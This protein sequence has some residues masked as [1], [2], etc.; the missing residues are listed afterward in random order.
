[1][2]WNCN[3]NPRAGSNDHQKPTGN[4]LI[5]LFFKDLRKKLES[6]WLAFN[7]CVVMTQNLINKVNFWMLKARIWGLI[8][9]NS[10]SALEPVVKRTCVLP[11]R[12]HITYRLN[13]NRIYKVSF[14]IN[15]FVSGT[16]QTQTNTNKHKVENQKQTKLIII[17]I[18]IFHYL[19]LCVFFGKQ[20][21]EI[22]NLWIPDTRKQFCKNTNTSK[23][24]K[25]TNMN[26]R[27]S[28]FIRVI[29]NVDCNNFPPLY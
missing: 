24:Y 18:I 12:A 28:C 1:M 29:I 15:E 23:M 16:I 17:M 9:H 19:Q 25:I 7:V 26:T 3:I 8:T 14:L 20:I 22:E 2:W 11:M 6:L 5:T 13:T 10:M 4:V 27:F 21:P